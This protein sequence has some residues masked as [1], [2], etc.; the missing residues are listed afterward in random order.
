MIVKAG[1][2]NVTTYFVLRTAADGTA[3]T[4][5]TI[6]NIDLQ[7]VRSGAAPSAKVDATALAATDSVH[8]DN[9]AFEIDGT[10]APGLYRVDWPDAA[11]AAGVREVILSVK[12]ATA[13]TEHLRVEIS[14]AVDVVAISGDT[15][16]ADNCEAMYD[17]TGYAGGTIVF[18][19]DLT[20]MGGVAQSA[21]DL[22][23]FADAGYD[24]A[25]NKVQ[26]VV[27][28]D[29]TTANTDMVGTDSAALASVL[30]AAVGAS[31]SADLA[32]VKAETVLILA[33]TD[34][35]GVAGA[36]LSAIP[37]NS[38]WDAEV[39]SEVTD[40]LTAYDPPTKAEMDTAT[41][42]VTPADGSITNAKFGAGAINA[43][44]IAANA[45]TNEKFADGAL[46]QAEIVID[47]TESANAADATSSFWER[48][49]SFCRTGV[50]TNKQDHDGSK[51]QHYNDAGAAAHLK[52]TTAE[53]AGTQ[54][55]GK[56]EDA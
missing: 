22:K 23:D 38:S 41:G 43:A 35:I 32:A 51:I 31:I 34:D 17:G 24:P 6:T 42:Q 12:Y 46:T 44:A 21:T 40:A 7:Y 29:T 8:G 18:H 11:F 16:A 27:L 19:A 28:V 13:F 55:K 36:G 14:P 52:Q 30:G 5:A 15:T 3:L 25:T 39:Q 26:G 47:D 56:V 45:L 33:D 37:W 10:D 54:T 4:G 20:K 49:K 9:K 48:L 2:T 50:G 53:A 1:S